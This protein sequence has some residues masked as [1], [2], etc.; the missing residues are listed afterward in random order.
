[1]SVKIK[2]NW[3][4]ENVVSESVRIYRSDSLITT[5]T[6]AMLIA[7]ILDDVYEYED[8][9]V[10]ED[11]TYFYMLSAK[12]GEQEAHTECFEIVTKNN[13]DLEVFLKPIQTVVAQHS[14]TTQIFEKCS[15]NLDG[16]KAIA[17]GGSLTQGE[18]ATYQTTTPFVLKNTDTKTNNF[19]DTSETGGISDI[20][21]FNKGRDVLI[22]RSS[23]FSLIHYVLSVPFQFDDNA[24]KVKK[25]TSFSG[26]SDGIF[27]I[28]TN[29]LYI[30]RIP[31][32]SLHI[33]A[34]SL[35]GFATIDQST[36]VASAQ[37]SEFSSIPDGVN[38]ITGIKV[39]SDGLSLWVVGQRFT[40]PYYYDY[41]TIIHIV[42]SLPYTINPSNKV[43]F[44]VKLIKQNE[45]LMSLSKTFG[46]VDKFSAATY[47]G[48][49][50]SYKYTFFDFT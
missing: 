20:L 15:F 3:D 34:Y 42:F 17:S 11:Q 40:P 19:I 35:N 47:I 9:D 16:S 50:L 46:N 24:E 25:V 22:H 41:G 33:E 7:T 8:F 30:Y 2:I 37:L 31:P 43:A 29:G 13:S 38:R 36:L 44:N 1:M 12:L 6:Q 26:K 45:G 48:S 27:Q 49:A 28:S 14:L 21:F 5:P 39:A 18:I 4:N 32:S 23:P 10:I